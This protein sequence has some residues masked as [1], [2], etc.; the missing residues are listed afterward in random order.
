M[1]HAYFDE[2]GK[3]QDSNFICLTGYIADDDQWERF[4]TE[5]VGLLERHHIPYVHMKHMI[6]LQGVYKELGWTHEHRDKVLDQFIEVIQRNILAAFAIGL[7]AKAYREMSAESKN[8]LGGDPFLFCFVRLINKV[9]TTLEK[10]G[11]DSPI[12]M[13][14]DN[15]QAYAMK[16]YSLWYKLRKMNPEHGKKI[17]AMCFAD[18]TIYQPLQGADVLAHQTNKFMRNVQEQRDVH[19]RFLRL[20]KKPTPPY[21][22]EFISEMFDLEGLKNMDN[23]LKKRNSAIN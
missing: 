18:D 3:F 6:A 1:L 11:Q 20:L 2:S 12:T 22:I 9:V 13:V 4:S 14:F 5:W 23:Q 10:K 21:V 7:D 16:L 15:D 19:P 17:G 8:R